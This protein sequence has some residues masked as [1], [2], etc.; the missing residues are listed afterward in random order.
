MNFRKK[1]KIHS[2]LN[3]TSHKIRRSKALQEDSL[4][5]ETVP[6]TGGRQ[7]ELAEYSSM[8]LSPKVVDSMFTNTWH[9]KK[10]VN[11]RTESV[12]IKDGPFVKQR[13][14]DL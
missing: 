1:S 14:L 7:T 13:M 9:D 10:F 11:L 6:T 12:S 8:A 5:E 3:R 4:L 2:S